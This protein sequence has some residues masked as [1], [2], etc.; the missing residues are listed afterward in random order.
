MKL[1]G[2]ISDITEI[3][4]ATWAI[5]GGSS[6]NSI[7][8]PQD[9]NDPRIEI[10]AKNLIFP[11]PFGNSPAFT[12]FLFRPE[13]TL[14]DKNK[15]IDEKDIKNSSLSQPV[16][17]LYCSMHGWRK[18][19]N[20]G[21]ASQQVFWVLHLAGV[22]RIL[23]EGGVGALNHLLKPGDLIVPRD[24]IDWSMRRDVSLGLPY[25]MIMRD[26]ICP[27]LHNGLVK[28]AEAKPLGRVFDRGIYVVTDGRH[29]ESC[30]E[31]A[32]MRQGPGDI[33]GQSLCPEV[34]LAREIGACYAGLYVVVNYAE[35]IIKEWDYQEF[36]RIF[37]EEAVHLGSLLLDAI[38][39]ILQK[40]KY[41]S[42]KSCECASLR[43]TT[44][45][46]DN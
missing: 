10:V 45:L 32:L 36:S 27:V 42:Q 30:S 19:V 1:L 11:T 23:G 3:K 12:Y 14:E 25:L 20:R 2:Q 39:K 31:V 24:Y 40:E 18:G 16:G 21:E 6:T 37:Y 33:V 15:V 38:E 44:M 43:K 28:A 46:K 13:L 17:V 26:P 8:F 22:K 41:E 4:G 7:N 5:I 34:F 29:F 9:L 35:G